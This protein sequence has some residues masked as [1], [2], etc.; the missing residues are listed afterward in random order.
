MP[1]HV[2]DLVYLTALHKGPAPECVAD[3]SAK[4]LA[5]VDY[6]QPRAI[7]FEASRC[8]ILEHCFACDLVLR[9][10]FPNAKY[11]LVASRIHAERTEHDVLA[12]V[13]PV[14]KYTPDVET[15]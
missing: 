6:K 11:A 15:L 5:A 14:D 2:P 3:R 12:K 1:E 9:R 13:N 4:S 10:A 7:R 8:E